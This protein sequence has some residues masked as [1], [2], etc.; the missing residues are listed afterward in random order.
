MNLNQLKY[1]LAIVKTGSFSNAADDMYISQSSMSKQIKALETE[2]GVDLFKREHSKVYLTEIGAEFAKYAEMTVKQHNDML[3]YLDEF[4]TKKSNTIRFGSI[5]VVSSYG[6]SGQIADFTNHYIPNVNVVIDM[7]ENNQ[8]RIMKELYEGNIDLALIRTDY[9]EDLDIFDIIP[10]TKDIFVLV[11][12]KDHPLT[13]KAHIH[14]EDLVPYPLSLLDTSSVI[15]TIVTKAF[16]SHGIKKKA[17]CLTTRHKILMEILQTSNDITLL[18]Q[19]LVDL[20]LFK[21]LTTVPLAE[22]VTS[23]VALI[24]LKNRKLNK[25]TKDFWNF[26]QK[27]LQM[28]Q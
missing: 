23:K 16:E 17:K 3:L 11:C 22:E 9:L 13:A 6:L 26:W 15:Y 18:P 25:I 28:Q 21:H 14:P 5:P 24:K 19:S 8:Q 2:L 1:F 10:Y 27:N 4:A 20:E 7:H 12:N